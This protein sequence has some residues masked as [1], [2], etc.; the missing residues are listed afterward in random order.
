[1]LVCNVLLIALAAAAVL[2][3]VW[4]ALAGGVLAVATLLAL[5]ERRARSVA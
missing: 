4:P 2:G 5:L 3:Y 1:M